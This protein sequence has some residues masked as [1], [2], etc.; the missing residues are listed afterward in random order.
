MSSLPTMSPQNNQYLSQQMNSQAPSAPNLSG[1][2]PGNSGLQGVLQQLQNSQNQANQANQTRYQDIL[3]MYS[4]LGQ[5]GAQQIQQQT[6]QMQGQNTQSMTSRGL[7]NTTVSGAMNN[8]I[9]SLGQQNLLNLQDTLTGQEAGAMMQMNQNGPNLG[10]YAG[11]LQQAGMG[12]P[13]SNA[14]QMQQSQMQ[15]AFNNAG[16]GGGGWVSSDSNFDQS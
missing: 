13:G 1:L 6:Q 9:A 11:L 3:G 16:M 8:Q 10:Q 14:A 4:N 5:S 2:F 7:G 12:Q 15:S